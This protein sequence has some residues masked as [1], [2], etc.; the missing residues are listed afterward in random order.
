MTQMD[1]NEYL[2]TSESVTAVERRGRLSEDELDTAGASDQG[3]VFGYATNETP[4]L[5]PMPIALAHR[6]SKQLAQV[7]K[8]GSL[9]YLRPDGKTQVTVRYCDDVPVGPSRSWWPST[10]TYARRRCV[11]TCSCTG[12]STLRLPPTAPSD[13]TIPTSPGSAPTARRHCGTAPG[14]PR[15]VVRGRGCLIR[16]LRRVWFERRAP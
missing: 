8:D 16:R 6:L 4:E 2:F 13:T 1:T 10:S 9:P 3:M 5:M 11:T 7:R 14:C 15:R 12:R